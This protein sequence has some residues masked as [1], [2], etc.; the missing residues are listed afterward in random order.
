MKLRQIAF[1][2][3]KLEPSEEILLDVLG[4]DVGF[5]DPGVGHFGLHNGVI[6]VGDNFLEIVAPVEGQTD[7]AAGRFMARRGGDAGY[8]VLLHVADGTGARERAAK[9]G[10]RAVWENNEDG[11]VATHFHPVDLGGVILSVDSF[12]E[13]PDPSEEW[14]YW[15][16]G[17]PDWLS[18]VRAGVT[19]AMVGME[20]VNPDPARQA[21][22][23]SSLL[24]AP[25]MAVTDGF[26]MPCADG[27]IIR[28]RETA[29]DMLP[30][31]SQIDFRMTDKAEA[32][33]RAKA[34]GLTHDAD[35]FT[36]MQVR[37]NLI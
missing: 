10:I 17:G 26:D 15:R 11:A 28:F 18:H 7:T 14:S 37:C 9:L 3:E 16:W 33:S 32:L 1:A 30:G 35:G 19:E 8:M 5:R 31:I 24:D 4:L 21:A 25:V 6:P 36:L 34:H 2:A 29:R 12:V 23:W 27:G 22:N 13:S 20:L